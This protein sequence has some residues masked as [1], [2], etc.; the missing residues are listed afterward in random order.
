MQ[1]LIENEVFALEPL[2]IDLLLAA[3]LIILIFR[4]LNQVK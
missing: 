1:F 3:L 4:Q 2:L